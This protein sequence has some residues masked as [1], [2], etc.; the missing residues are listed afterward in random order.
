[1]KVIIVLILSVGL[2]GVALADQWDIT[3]LIPAKDGVSAQT[4]N[5]E[6]REA[7]FVLEGVKGKIPANCPP[8]AY[9]T[10]SATSVVN[11]GDGTIYELR[12]TTKVG[13]VGAFALIPTF[14]TSPGTLTE[15]GPGATQAD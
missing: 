11:C 2:S 8:N 14:N 13:K 4:L 9:W 1:M 7:Q 15:L 10:L 6:T 3:I 12:K 5:L